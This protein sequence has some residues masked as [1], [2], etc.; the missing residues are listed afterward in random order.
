MDFAKFMAVPSAAEKAASDAVHRAA[1]DFEAAGKAVAASRAALTIRREE[2]AIANAGI[3]EAEKAAE[4]L[5][6][7]AKAVARV[8]RAAF[9]EAE[10]EYGRAQAAHREAKDEV[11]AKQQALVTAKAKQRAREAAAIDKEKGNAKKSREG[12]PV[13][14]DGGATFVAATDS[15]EAMDAAASPSKAILGRSEAASPSNSTASSCGDPTACPHEQPKRERFVTKAA[16]KKEK[17]RAAKEAAAAEEARKL[18]RKEAKKER[19]QAEATAKELAEAAA[20]EAEKERRAAA[21]EAR[22]TR[23]AAIRIQCAARR[24]NARRRCAELHRRKLQSKRF[25]AVRSWRQLL[26]GILRDVGGLHRL[27]L[28]ANPAATKPAAPAEEV[29]R[30]R[31]TTLKEALQDGN[32]THVRGN[33]HDLYKRKA[34]IDGRIVTQ[35]TTLAK[36]PSDHRS[37]PN[38][39]AKMRGK[40]DEG[41]TQSFSFNCTEEERRIA[42]DEADRLRHDSAVSADAWTDD[43][44]AS[45]KVLIVHATYLAFQKSVA[46]YCWT[47]TQRRRALKILVAE[48]QTLQALEARPAQEVPTP[49]EQRKCMELPTCRLEDKIKWLRKE[50][51]LMIDRGQLTA[52]EKRLLAEEWQHKLSDEE[53]KRTGASSRAAELLRGKLETLRKSE[54]FTRKPKHAKEIE[55]LERMLTELAEL[56]SSKVPVPLEELEKLYAK[57]RLL[58]KLA[59]LKNASRGWFAEDMETDGQRC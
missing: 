55:A 5:I 3:R 45:P 2:E 27:L 33:N 39:L 46:D 18:Q 36:T 28:A 58:A 49:E 34:E 9:E 44:A 7:D 12:P 38:Q 56:E 22:R 48:L 35:I 6:A 16:I 41:V 4:R 30:S 57:P 14:S 19:R 17:E 11:T 59:E 53:A 43:D 40:L 32:W 51:E 54:P 23:P 1:V 8:A 52:D 20:K 26:L 50:L 25:A 21:R 37:L 31:P 15:S 47:Y 10:A 29:R 42:Q 24:L 13:E